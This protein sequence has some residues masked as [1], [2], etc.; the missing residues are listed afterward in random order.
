MVN[1]EVNRYRTD[2]IDKRDNT[3]RYLNSEQSEQE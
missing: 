2:T 3:K 1:S